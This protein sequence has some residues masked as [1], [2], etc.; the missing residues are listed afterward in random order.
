[1]SVKVKLT[2]SPTIW[3]LK[4]DSDCFITES[5]EISAENQLELTNLNPNTNCCCKSTQT[6]TALQI[7]EKEQ[8]SPL[9]MNV[10]IR[11]L[12]KIDYTFLRTGFLF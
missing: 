1:M 5:V 7:S 11:H 6:L 3:L 4:I 10:C 12:K 9:V 2:E 8:T